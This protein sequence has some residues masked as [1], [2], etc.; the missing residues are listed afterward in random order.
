MN[1]DIASLHSLAV[2]KTD[3]LFYDALLTKIFQH[4]FFIFELIQFSPVA[5]GI[6]E[7]EL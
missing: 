6:L 2:C 5:V 4:V 7:A 3:K 1:K